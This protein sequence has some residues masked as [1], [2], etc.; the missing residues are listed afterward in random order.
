VSQFE[1]IVVPTG[2]VLGLAI[3]HLLSGLGKTLFRL[4]GHGEP[5]KT[6][7]VHTIW[8][9]NSGFWV[10]AFWWY[11]FN[12]SQLEVW[13]LSAY[14]LLIATPIMMYLQCVI[15]FPDRFD[16]IPDVG[17][18]FLDIRKW[19]YSLFIVSVLVDMADGLLETGGGDYV[20]SLGGSMLVITTLSVVIPLAGCITRNLRAQGAL[21][22][23]LLLAQIWQVF[24]DH[25]YL[26][27]HLPGGGS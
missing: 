8:V 17:Q 15:L 19:Y 26:G 7:W 27:S 20:T 14:L 16:D 2:I 18:Y 23:L 9:L 3:A 21:G 6:S 13:P 10:Y 5:I 4:T 22:V 12:R 25:P 24:N 1:Y 11:S